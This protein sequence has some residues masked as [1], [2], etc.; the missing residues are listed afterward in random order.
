M[1]FAQELK[2]FAQGFSSTLNAFS[3]FKKPKKT[4]AEEELEANRAAIESVGYDA[5]GSPVDNRPGAGVGGEAAFR[6][7]RGVD[8]EDDDEGGTKVAGGETSGVEFGDDLDTDRKN[9]RIA[10]GETSGVEF[11]GE[12]KKKY[13]SFIAHPL[14]IDR[15]VRTTWAESSRKSEDETKAIAGVIVN[16]AKKAGTNIGSEVLKKG[17]FE[18][19]GNPQAR[20]RMLSLSPHSEEYQRIKKMIMPVLEGKEDPSGGATYF[21][22]PKAQRAL[23]RRPPKWDDGSGEDIGETRFF[24]HPYGERRRERQRTAAVELE[25]EDFQPDV[26]AATGGFIPD[27]GNSA[28]GGSNPAPM[29]ADE[30]D[31]DNDPVNFDEAQLVDLDGAAEAVDGGLKYLQKVFGFDKPSAV[32]EADDRRQDGY[33]AFALNVGAASPQDMQIIQDTVD[34]GHRLTEEQRLVAGYHAAY[35]YHSMKGNPAAAQR[36][37]AAMLMYSKAAAQRYGS[38]AIA[39]KDEGDFDGMAKAVAKGYDLVPDGKSITATKAGKDGVE[40]QVVDMEGNITEKGKASIDDVVR[41]ATGMVDGTAW[42]QSLGVLRGKK[43]G[44]AEREERRRAAAEDFNIEAEGTGEDYRDTLSDEAKKKFDAMDVR[45]QRYFRSKYA[46][47]Q[48]QTKAQD[49]AREMQEDRQKLTQEQA[50]LRRQDAEDRA[51]A[52]EGSVERRFQIR[53]EDRADVMYRKEAID[54]FKLA[55]K[56]NNWERERERVMSNSERWL[57]QAERQELGRDKRLGLSMDERRK[58][59]AEIDERIIRK[60]SDAMAAGPKLTAGERR[61]R[62]QTS[63]IDLEAEEQTGLIN[64]EAALSDEGVPDYTPRQRQQKQAVDVGADFSHSLVGRE[65]PDVD[66]FRQRVS[67]VEDVITETLSQM[68]NGK[69]PNLNET[70][71]LGRV[72]SDVMRSSELGEREAALVA[73]DA[74]TKKVPMKIVG[75]N[76]VQFG[77]RPPVRLSTRTMMDIFQHRGQEPGSPV[78][79]RPGRTTDAAPPPDSTA[80]T[81]S[82]YDTNPARRRREERAT[83]EAVDIGLARTRE[84]RESDAAELDRLKAKLGDDWREGMTV[85][86]AREALRDL[87]LE[88]Q[89]GASAWRRRNWA[90]RGQKFWDR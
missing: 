43:P 42:F 34:P 52:K 23:G 19:W 27:V 66:K 79:A 56:Q 89:E 14:D 47:E 3:K 28:S 11:S 58:R 71:K 35:K 21:Y 76:M 6:S 16:R 1:G 73:I 72:A 69:T 63:A 68:T 45:E 82:K 59:Y 33:K 38:L 36:A 74:Y 65:K 67:K 57:A 22:A 10:G 53:R 62:S 44:V 12:V 30:D 9:T 80:A 84:R 15:A 25:E 20:Q 41:M 49:F 61:E 32:T 5:K 29:L 4:A 51:A 85:D 48:G 8:I 2:D 46:K 18:P 81:T 83:K 54:A 75:R 7:R 37:A 26:Y 55:L 70:V 39:A 87:Q 64:R 78:S 86:Q 17:Q 50:E 88:R 90:T 31:D 13:P 24:R 40:F 77:G 60:R